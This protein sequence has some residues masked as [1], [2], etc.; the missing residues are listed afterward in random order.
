MPKQ[1]VS[2]SGIEYRAITKRGTDDQ[3]IESIVIDV[4]RTVYRTPQT[5]G[6]CNTIDD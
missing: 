2:G 1:D 6:L 4:A 3:I 5:I